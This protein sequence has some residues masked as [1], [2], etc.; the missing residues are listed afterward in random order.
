MGVLANSFFIDKILLEFLYLEVQILVVL[1]IMSIF[2]LARSLLIYKSKN[3]DTQTPSENLVDIR[4]PAI[5]GSS[6]DSRDDKNKKK[7]QENQES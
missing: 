7:D 6:D 1:T 2:S 4:K 5:S 3:N